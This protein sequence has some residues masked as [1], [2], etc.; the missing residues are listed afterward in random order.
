MTWTSWM[1]SG[2]SKL[3]A[4]FFNQLIKMLKIII[5]FLMNAWNVW[6]WFKKKRGT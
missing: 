4:V 1:T 2:V 5:I 3:S 6:W